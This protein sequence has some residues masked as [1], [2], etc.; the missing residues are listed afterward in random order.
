VALPAFSQAGES[1]ARAIGT[2]LTL[3]GPRHVVIYGPDALIGSGLGS[4]AADS[5]MAGVDKF[6]DHTF[7]IVVKQVKQCELVTESLSPETRERG[8]Q[9]AALAALNRHFF[10]SLEPGLEHSQ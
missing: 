8:A 3:F 5:F 2:L 10:V 7:S 9:G 6:L 4:A 1:I